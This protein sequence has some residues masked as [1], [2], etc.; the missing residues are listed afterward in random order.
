MVRIG[1][2]GLPDGSRLRGANPHG[3]RSRLQGLVDLRIEDARSRQ[4]KDG[5]L[6]PETIASLKTVLR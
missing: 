2:P 5:P 4:A 1:R 6:A 3:R